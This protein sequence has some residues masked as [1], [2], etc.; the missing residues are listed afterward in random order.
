METKTQVINPVISANAVINQDK[1]VQLSYDTAGVILN[2]PL[3][4]I[5]IEAGFNCRDEYELVEL[6]KSIA[7]IGIK[8]P[9]QCTLDA[10]GNPVVN[11]GHN[12]ILAARLANEKYN[13]KVKV[14]PTMI[15][16]VSEE[17][18][19][20]NLIVLNSGKPIGPL[21]EGMVFSRLGK[22]GK[23]QKEIAKLCGNVTQGTVCNGLALASA[24]LIVQSA[25]KSGHI[26]ATLA[27]ELMR[28]AKDN[29]K[30]LCEQFVRLL[31]L[32]R[33]QGED[34]ITAKFV[35]ANAI[36]GTPP[37]TPAAG[38]PPVTPAKPA[39]TEITFELLDTVLAAMLS[40]SEPTFDADV[41]LSVAME[42]QSFRAKASR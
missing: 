12:R 23:T 19:I 1:P 9:I 21:A 3:K 4:D 32:M 14:V 24:P 30:A 5:Q 26:S 6:A 22:L 33:R 31:D 15:I 17:E 38:T 37:V 7:A 42:L 27:L 25:I 10:N 28:K 36:V 13:G 39:T 11:N 29:T 8:Q 40:Y 2:I 41:F 35:K 34:C 18:R 16:K 20:A